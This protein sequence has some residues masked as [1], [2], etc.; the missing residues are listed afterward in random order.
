M[1]LNDAFRILGAQTQPHIR[2]H[3]AVA[4]PAA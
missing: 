2:L 4:L 1:T 3:R